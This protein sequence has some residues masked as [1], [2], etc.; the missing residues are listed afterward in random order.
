MEDILKLWQTANKIHLKES[1]V[2]RY[3]NLIDIHILPVLGRFPA[4]QISAARINQFLS[5]KLK[6]GRIDG[7]GGLS[8]AYV[9]SLSVILNSAIRYG[10][11]EGLCKPLTSAILKPQLPKKE[12][13]ILSKKEQR[14]LENELLSNTDHNKLLIYITLYS[15]LRI[16]EVCALRWEDID[17]ESRIIQVRHTVSRSWHICNNKKY[18]LLYV[19]PPKTEASIRCIP[20]CSKL[21]SVISSFSDKNT[22]G[23]ILTG[24]RDGEFIS[25]RTFEY[26]YKKILAACG[27]DPVNYHALRHTFA[28]RCVEQGVDTKSL[29]E[30]LGHANAAITLNTY[31]HSSMEQKRIQ[32]E[33]LI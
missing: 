18:S 1:S 8:P 4:D 2:S 15:G 28:T 26:R 16:G 29:S 9:R 19:G 23:Y 6:N 11:G 32:L 17:M 21:Y 22:P 3:Q 13:H 30:I 31:V 20:I 7:S 33:K 12:M 25:P 10:A 27:L 24:D 5:E 14:M